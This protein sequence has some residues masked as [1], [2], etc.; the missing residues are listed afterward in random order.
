MRP[1]IVEGLICLRSAARRPGHVRARGSVAAASRRPRTRTMRALELA[2]ALSGG[3]R[4]G[5]A[6]RLLE[7]GGAERRAR[8]NPSSSGSRGCARTCHGRRRA[9]AVILRRDLAESLAGAKIDR[10]PRLLPSFDTFLLAHA[11]ERPPGRAELLQ[12]RLPKPGLALSRR[13]RQRPHRRRLVSGAASEDLHRR[14]PARSRASTSD[15][16]DG[17]H[18]GSRGARAVCR[19]PLRRCGSVRTPN[20]EP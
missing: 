5:D 14:R 17:I 7:V 11:D 4:S 2:T 19:R 6:P 10:R 15:V 1:A 13:D 8:R 18:A 12:A 9:A 3:V 16:R 20:L